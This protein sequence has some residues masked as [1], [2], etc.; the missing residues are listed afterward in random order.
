MVAH[1]SD[2]VFWNCCVF[3]IV[4]GRWSATRC[5][6]RA[7]LLSGAGSSGAAGFS[8]APAAIPPLWLAAGSSGPRMGIPTAAGSP[9]VVDRFL[10]IVVGKRSIS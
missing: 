9:L 7:D 4:I 5:L 6:S 10:L 3:F 1:G 8:G 2:T